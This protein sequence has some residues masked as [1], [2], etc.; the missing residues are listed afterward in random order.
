M[1]FSSK[2]YPLQILLR[3]YREALRVLGRSPIQLSMASCKFKY[4]RVEPNPKKRLTFPGRSKDKNEKTAQLVSK[5][6]ESFQ[7]ES[8][9]VE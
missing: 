7:A 9:H 6:Y 3:G 8:Q 1:I 5:S 2:D 4:G